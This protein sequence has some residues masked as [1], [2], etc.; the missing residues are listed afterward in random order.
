MQE[1]VWYCRKVYLQ[2]LGSDLLN[3]EVLAVFQP[4]HKLIPHLL[5]LLLDVLTEVHLVPAHHIPCI[6]GNYLCIMS[7]TVVVDCGSPCHQH[8][9]RFVRPCQQNCCWSSL[10]SQLPSVSA[11]SGKIL[12]DRHNADWQLWKL[13]ACTDDIVNMHVQATNAAGLQHRFPEQN[14]ITC[15]HTRVRTLSGRYLSVTYTVTVGTPSSKPSSNR[16]C[17]CCTSA[18]KE[19]LRNA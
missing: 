16:V 6:E 4:C 3:G 19:L 12:L 15:V 5:V 1:A 7:Q 18:Y 14:C 10:P 17:L 11:V 2:S 8:K 9:G 13:S